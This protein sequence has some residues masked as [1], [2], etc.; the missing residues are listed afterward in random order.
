MR[1]GYREYVVLPEDA[2]LLRKAVHESAFG[3]QDDEEQG[4]VI[5]L[6][7]SKG[8][9]GVSF[10]AIHLAA[11]LSPVHRVCVVDMDFSMGD[12]AAFL[13]LQPTR[14]IHDLIHDLDNLDPRT[15][16]RSVLVHPSK[17]HVLPQPTELL[18]REDI[19]GDDILRVLT[20][21]AQAYQ[22]VLVDCGG[23]IDETTLTTTSVSDLVIIVTNPDVVAV[24]NAW[25]RLQLMERLGIPRDT[26]RLVVN[27]WSKTTDL[28]IG[29]IET[30]LEIPVAA[31]ISA[32]PETCRKAVNR[33]V[34]LREVDR[35]SP[36]ARDIS[37]AVELITNGAERVSSAPPARSFWKL[38]R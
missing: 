29:D 23:R 4:E 3:V 14:S 32:D 1:A 37:A 33:G 10:L 16:A 7:G 18:D 27:K 13:D 6:V 25:R 22:Y 8:G 35:S 30:N 26:L 21:T 31:T 38:F 15:L 19:Q 28:S 9:A 2:D 24:K 12:V 34:L 20:A 36:A 11:E 5:S 17:V